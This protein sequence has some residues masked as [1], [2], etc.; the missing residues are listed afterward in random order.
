[1]TEWIQY[2]GIEFRSAGEIRE[3]QERQLAAHLV[4]AA[5]NSPFYRELL[6]G[7]SPDAA[8]PWEMLRELPFT[9]KE[10]FSERNDDFLAVPMERIVE[11]ALS[12]GTTCRPTKVMYTER[13]LKRLAYNEKISFESCGMSASDVVLLTCTLDRCFI[14]GLAYWDGVRALGAAAIRNGL[15]SFESHA[16]L[17]RR[18]KP[19]VLVGVP[20]FLLKLGKFL[21]AEGVDP[22]GTGIGKLV[23]IG[24]PVRDRELSFLHVGGLLEELWG[25]RVYSTYASSE[26]ITSF[27]ECTAQRG[28]H[29]HPELALVEIVDDEGR[30]LPAGEVGEVVTTPFAIEGMPLVRFKTGDISFLIEEPCSCGRNSPRLG[31][32]LGRKN[33]MIKF[34]GTT[35][36]PQAIFSVLDSL[37]GVSDYYVTA[38]GEYHLSDTLRVYVALRDPDCTPQAI[39]DKLQSLLRVRPEVTVVSEAQIRSQLSAGNS[40]KAI[41]FLDQRNCL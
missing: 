13:D 22:A 8:T 37:P 36:Y 21:Q 14:G 31:P 28:G 4:Y 6:A 3:I 41:R 11:I 24:E 17:I 18:L 30:V 32:I 2:R 40:R 7:R 9:D 25:A 38:T 19:T 10:Q 26:T 20:T 35:L 34:R 15:S 23:C 16:E 33:Q 27:C 12:S 39:M 1:M 5:A 29:L